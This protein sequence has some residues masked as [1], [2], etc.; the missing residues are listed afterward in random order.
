MNHNAII[1][2]SL[3][4]FVDRTQAGVVMVSGVLTKEQAKDNAMFGDNVVL[5]MCVFCNRDKKSGGR[6][7]QFALN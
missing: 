6:I 5:A 7:H 4:L 1:N 3:Y 2:P